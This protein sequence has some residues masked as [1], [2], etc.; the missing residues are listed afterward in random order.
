M[1]D[2]KSKKQRI[3]SFTHFELYTHKYIYAVMQM[4]E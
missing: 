2:R 3:Q 4:W 1:R